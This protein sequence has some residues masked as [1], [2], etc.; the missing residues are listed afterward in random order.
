MGGDVAGAADCGGRGAKLGL[1][2]GGEGSDN[3]SF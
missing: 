1:E 3:M 2:R